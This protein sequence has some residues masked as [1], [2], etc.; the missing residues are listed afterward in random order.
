[1]EQTDCI[2]DDKRYSNGSELCIDDR[3]MRCEDGEW[4]ET[5]EFDIG[6]GY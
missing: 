2:Y 6:Y 3:C 4:V 5:G 1:M